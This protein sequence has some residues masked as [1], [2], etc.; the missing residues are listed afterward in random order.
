MRNILIE[1]EE[2]NNFV[3]FLD[4]EFLSKIEIGKKDVEKV[5]EI[6]KFNI[7]NNSVRCLASLVRIYSQN[8]VEHLN[9]VLENINAEN[10]RYYSYA[11]GRIAMFYNREK[12]IKDYTQILMNKFD[13]IKEKTQ[14]LPDNFS[15][16]VQKL[17]ISRLMKYVDYLDFDSIPSIIADCLNHLWNTKPHDDVQVVILKT[18]LK[19]IEYDIS[20]KFLKKLD[21]ILNGAVTHECKDIVTT[22]IKAFRSRNVRVMKDLFLLKLKT[23]EHSDLNIQTKAWTIISKLTTNSLFLKQIYSKDLNPVAIFRKYRAD[24]VLTFN[25]K[26]GYTIADAAIKVLIKDI[27]NSDKDDELCK[28]LL[29]NIVTPLL[30]EE[31][32]KDATVEVINNK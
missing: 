32:F 4:N 28:V 8:P 16:S 1:T 13:T 17:L 9:F 21:S 11:I 22:I 2:M 30:T 10:C 31:K 29:E 12:F 3:Q 15:L 14:Q 20:G 18:V 24:A 7:Y 19:L 23:L 6:Y 25:L 27:I 5:P 26:Q